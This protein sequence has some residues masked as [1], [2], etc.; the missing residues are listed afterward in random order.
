ML[1]V[2]VGDVFLVPLVEVLIGLYPSLVYEENFQR[3]PRRLFPVIK[4]SLDLVDVPIVVPD[5][6]KFFPNTPLPP[7]PCTS[8]QAARLKFSGIGPYSLGQTPPFSG[9]KQGITPM[10]RRRACCRNASRCRPVPIRRPPNGVYPL[11][12]SS[13]FFSLP[14]FAE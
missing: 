11:H 5:S 4:R 12:R 7:F 3:I 8:P 14:R 13:I 1:P 6:R 10:V 2:F 9:F